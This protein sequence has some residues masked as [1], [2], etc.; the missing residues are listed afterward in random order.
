MNR[1]ETARRALIIWQFYP[2]LCSC[3]SAC[4]CHLV[5]DD[6][7]SGFGCS[8]SPSSASLPGWRTHRSSE[9]GT[10]R[11]GLQSTPYRIDRW[12][13]TVLRAHLLVGLQFVLFDFDQ[14]APTIRLV[15][16]LGL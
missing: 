3:C 7:G 2:A 9:C 6:Y 13:E 1:D 16:K 12:I 8:S 14:Y 4:E 15:Q 5:A 11:Q 10:A